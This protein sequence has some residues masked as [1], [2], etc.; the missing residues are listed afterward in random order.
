MES[1]SLVD[2]KILYDKEHGEKPQHQLGVL[3]DGGFLS[4]KT[5]HKFTKHTYCVFRE[6]GWPVEKHLFTT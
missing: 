5:T 6:E 4:R 2:P 3:R 1:N